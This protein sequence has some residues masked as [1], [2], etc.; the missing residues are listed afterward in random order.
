MATTREFVDT[1]WYRL[2]KGKPQ[3]TTG[4]WRAAVQSV[5]SAAL[6]RLA[7]RIAGDDALYPL[8][9]HEWDVTLGIGGVAGQAIL[10]GPSGLDPVILLSAG[11]R[12]RVRVT[13]DDPGPGPSGVLPP[14]QYLP[15]FHDLEIPSPSP[16]SRL[17]RYTFW[18]QSLVIR[19]GSGN[20]DDL[21]Q[22]PVHL[23]G[24]KVPAIDD[25][26]FDGE[27]FDDLCDVGAALCM[28]SQSVM[29]TVRQAEEGAAI[30]PPLSS[31]PA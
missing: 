1:V 20:V 24:C 27:L 8:L 15:N 18:Q 19:T 26:V 3:P 17:R 7:D 21:V 5:L 13:M 31:A 30:H 11:A 23:F 10:I 16:D 28:E 25:P 4:L 2:S 12:K 22:T 6:Q 29:E 9:M 14:A